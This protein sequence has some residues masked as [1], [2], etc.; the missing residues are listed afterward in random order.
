MKK[1]LI[2][3]I[4]LLVFVVSS[5]QIGKKQVDEKNPMPEWVS[6]KPQNSMY[7]I[8]VSSSPK[9]G[10]LPSDYMANAQQKAL[11]DMSSSISVKIE[12]TSVLS[13]I[14]TNYEIT[15]NFTS[16][17]IAS[18]NQQLEGYELVDTWEDENYYWVYYRLSKSEYQTRKE[19]KKQQT[20]LDAKN[21]YYQ[22]TELIGRQLHYNAFLFYIEALTILKPYLGESTLTDIE[23]EEKDLGN[24]L[25]CSID[26]FVNSLEIVFKS[27][28]INVKKGVALDPT[29][30]SFKI[31]DQ[32]GYPV[33]GIPVKINFTGLG[34]LR[35]SEV[36][37]FDG[38][39]YPAIKK[40][41]SITNVETMS[42]SI[43]M[44]SFSRSAKDPLIRSLIKGI[45]ASNL[46]VR[47]NI[48]KPVLKI[49]S[50]EKS[51]GKI[52]EDGDQ[53]QS[54]FEGLLGGDFIITNSENPDYVL[55]ITSN[56]IK[57]GEN[58][59]ESIVTMSYTF[60]L[61]DS[62]GNVIYR[63]TSA[64]DYSGN[65]FIA[66]DNLAYIEVTKS[67]ERIIARELISA[68]NK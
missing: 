55:K 58:Y 41:K 37:A 17:I 2:S 51:F 32:R 46:T 14:E 33:S 61:S 16:E 11:A 64:T 66:A 39:I 12:S 13:L 49:L 21:K 57:N 43:D 36:S 68:I 67:I 34:L 54:A 31:V 29:V 15:E 1:L 53:L 59:G 24:V 56:T 10:F 65:N 30:F 7:Y 42:I 28:E 25:F 40:I 38:K 4:I 48:E 5:C 35:N 23:G 52:R 63:K 62:K 22:A 20:V 6:A 19:N 18:T 44:L 8:G 3:I 45:P 60:D 27:E 26:E 50:E 47:V 9:K